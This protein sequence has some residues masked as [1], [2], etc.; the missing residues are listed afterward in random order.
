MLGSKRLRKLSQ[1][2]KWLNWAFS[3]ISRTQ[4]GLYATFCHKTQLINTINTTTT[5]HHQHR[6]HQ[7]QYRHQHHQYP[8]NNNG[9]HYQQKQNQPT[10]TGAQWNIHTDVLRYIV[11]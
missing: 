10:H 2:L 11:F 4:H 3:L 6:Q 9:N 7:Q 1:L 5:I 8:N